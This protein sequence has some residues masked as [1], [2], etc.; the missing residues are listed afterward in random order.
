MIPRLKPDLSWHEIATLFKINKLDDVPEFECAFA[1][2]MG[3]KHAIFFPYGRTG[4]LFLLEALGISDQEIIC[5]AYTCVVVPHA[6]VLSRNEP[7]FVDSNPEDFNMNWD[8]VESVTSSNTAAVIATSLF[9]N[10]VNLDALKDYMKKNPNVFII[11]DCAHS[12]AASW[13]GEQ[14]QK[15]GHAAFYGSNI[16]K[17][18][19]SI[20]GGMVTTDDSALADRLHYIRDKRITKSSFKKDIKMRLYL[21]GAWLTFQDSIY[22]F[23]NKLEHLGF[24]DHFIQYYDENKIDMPID[25]LADT[26][27]TQGRIG[28]IQCKRY[29]KIL[30]GRKKIANYYNQKLRDLG[31]LILPSMI[32]GTTYSHYVVQT[33]HRKALMNH[34]LKRGVQLG[35]LIEYCIP[36][37]PSYQRRTG[38]R[39]TYPVA[40][41]LSRQTVNLPISLSGSTE[42]ASKVISTLLTFP[43]N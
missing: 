28:T 35:Q 37:M 17:I 39:M 32:E 4:L 16:S 24:L 36:D 11:Q 29:S 25:F 12:Y 13:K 10:P 14:V 3:K 2:L 21:L 43:F 5:P 33:K 22:G 8:Q 18:I 30:I 7:V 40:S 23:T 42:K 20:F 27:P 34:A 1:T 19:T 15:V 38:N 9:G 31:D 26:T 41:R 6:I